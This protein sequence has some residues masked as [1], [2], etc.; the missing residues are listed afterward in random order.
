MEEKNIPVTEE[1]IEKISGGDIILG[2]DLDVR[3][4][5]KTCGWVKDQRMTGTLPSVCPECGGD[6]LLKWYPTTY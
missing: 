5:C 2:N 4:T 6:I 3:L 1:L